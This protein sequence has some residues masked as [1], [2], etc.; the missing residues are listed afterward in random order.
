MIHL[1]EWIGYVAAS[2]TTASFVPQAWLTFK[3]RDV[4]GI[5]LGMYSAFTLGIALWL[6]YGWLIQAW[7]VVIANLITL[8]LAASILVMRLRFAR[9]ASENV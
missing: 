3:T 4:R 2:L 7:P 8:V 5:S 6:V 1:T 9:R